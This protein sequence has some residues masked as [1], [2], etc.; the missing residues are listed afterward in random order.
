MYGNAVTTS[1]L[2]G[3]STIAVTTG[4][5]VVGWCTLGVTVLASLALTARKLA[6]RGRG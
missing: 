3:A 6:R 5:S 4:W 2:A 1:A